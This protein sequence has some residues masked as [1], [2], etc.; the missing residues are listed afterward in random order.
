M[1]AEDRT[2]SLDEFI[3]YLLKKWKWIAAAVVIC[4]ALAVS[5][6]IKN[7]QRIEAAPSEEY[8]F[9][10]EQEADFEEYMEK[11]VIMQM[12]PMEIYE[13]TIVAE[14]LSDGE[15]VSGSMELPKFWEDWN[16]ETETEYLAELITSEIANDGKSVKL[17]VRHREEAACREL[18]TYVV[19][20]LRESDPK[21]EVQ[22]SE[23]KTVKDE[24][25]S[26]SQMWYRNRLKDIR[27]Q[28]EYA[29]AGYVIEVS[30]TS[31][32]VLGLIAGA[33]SSVMILFCCFM[34][35]KEKI[36]GSEKQI[37]RK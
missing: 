25:V 19:E 34:V 35:H 10:K 11:S 32:A 27:G 18:S 26:D 9:L 5:F 15:T 14:N 21:A 33:L 23:P 30:R 13:T 24:A 6:S 4:T 37:D 8:L 12:N 36:R 16:G 17:K 1:A 29:G 20:K 31:A 7:G 3:K 2:V 28:L 22:V